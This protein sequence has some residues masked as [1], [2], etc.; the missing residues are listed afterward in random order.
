MEKAHK[1]INKYIM[2]ILAAAICFAA[3]PV[4]ALSLISDEETEVFLHQTLK[5]IFQ[6]SGTTFN[7]RNIYIV[8]DKS[9]NAFVADGNNMFVTVGTLMNADSQNEISGVLAHE[10]GHI[11]GGHLLR[12]KIQ[13]REVQRVSLASML[14]GGAAGIAAGRP[15]ISIAAILGSQGSAMSNMLSYQVSEE[16]SADEA[17]IKLL[18]RINQ[19]PAGMLSFMKKIQKNNTL[20]GI[21]ETSYYRTHPVTSERIAFLEKATKDSNAP[22][23]GA[24]ESTF[25]RIKAKLY[26]YIEEPKNTFIKYPEG[27]NSLPARYAR[28]IAYFKQMKMQPATELIDN[29]IQEEPQ[30]P[31]FYELKGQMAME[32]GNVREAVNIYRK[33]LSLRPNSSLFKLN[34]AQA[35][36]ENS[37][38]PAEQQQ[39]VDMLNQVLI[40]NPDSYAWILLSRAYGLQQNAAG[41]NYAAA[42]Y[43]LRIHDIRLAKQQAEQALKSNPSQ[44]LRLK[45]DDLMMR[46]KDE[47]KEM[48]KII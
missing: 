24:Q 31:Y 10:T 28:T 14:L 45:L 22:S 44:T 11:E 33:A 2:S 3:M 20:Q 42:E 27:D 12:H 17:A 16:R 39:I 38:N 7:P 15:D 32:T 37:P 47:E 35:M 43:S 1:R 25:S 41:Y 19:S 5:P 6:A 36:L 23:T 8:N 26:A 13:A 48:K 34:L 21:E 30:N 29:L 40:Y 4:W 46:I 18:R 9:L